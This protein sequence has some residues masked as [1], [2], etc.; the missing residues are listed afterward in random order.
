[1]ITNYYCCLEIVSIGMSPR[2][3]LEQWC[4]TWVPLIM[5]PTTLGKPTILIK[6]ACCFS[7]VWWSVEDHIVVDKSDV[8]PMKFDIFT[9]VIL[10][11]DLGTSSPLLRHF[12]KAKQQ[13]QFLGQTIF[14]DSSTNLYLYSY[15]SVNSPL[16]HNLAT[17]SDC[18]SYFQL[19][20]VGNTG[21]CFFPFIFWWFK[22]NVGS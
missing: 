3:Q 12:S 14:R 2:L 5:A 22:W 1:M 17:F 13:N 11:L 20:A 18:F 19:K 4:G 10:S 6:V 9:L 8:R 16:W 7:M 21:Q 15:R